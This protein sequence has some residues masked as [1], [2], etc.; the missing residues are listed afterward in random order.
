MR[1]AGFAEM[2]DP[3]A[4]VILEKLIERLDVEVGD[5]G[6]K[7]FSTWV[8]DEKDFAPILDRVA[9]GQA[10]LVGA[11]R[12]AR[13]ALASG[14]QERIARA[15]LLCQGIERTGRDVERRRASRRRQD[16]GNRRGADQA[17]TAAEFWRP[18]IAKFRDLTRGG[19]GA[20]QARQRVADEMSTA[21]VVLSGGQF[22]SNETLRARLR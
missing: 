1:G 22:P 15:A 16:G 18:W 2:N 7:A 12:E 17:T 13:A 3:L 8:T 11:L 4:A 9:R 21:G 10:H 5:V 14:D 6:R 20:P 19:M